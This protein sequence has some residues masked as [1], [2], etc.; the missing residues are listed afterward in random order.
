MDRWGKTIPYVE[1][2]KNKG[3]E[4]VMNLTSARRRGN[5]SMTGVRDWGRVRRRALSAMG[6]EWRAWGLCQVPG[7]ASKK[8]L[9]RGVTRGAVQV[10]DTNFAATPKPGTSQ[11]QKNS[12]GDLAAAAPNPVFKWNLTFLVGP[13]SLPYCPASK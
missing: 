5:A 7:E 3:P 9:G 10:K 8:V 2:S 13:S 1:N 11:P 12:G 6:K 4:A